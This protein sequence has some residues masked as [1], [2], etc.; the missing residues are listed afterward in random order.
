LKVE[1]TLSK[2]Q[3]D[4][5]LPAYGFIRR[6]DFSGEIPPTTQREINAAVRELNDRKEDW[7]KL[8]LPERIKILG[9]ILEN[10]WFVKERW[11][12]LS[13]EAKGTR[14]N[15]Y[16]EAE[17]WAIF[18]NVFRMVRL[19]RK[20]L[21]QIQENGRPV[22]PGPMSVRP[23]GQVVAKVFPQSFYDRLLLP[24]TTAEVWM[25]PDITLDDVVESQAR[26]YRQ[27]SREGKVTLV[28][29]AGNASMLVPADF[30]Y[31]LFVEGHVVILKLNPVNA[32]LGDTLKVAFQALIQPGFLRIVYGGAEEGGY[33]CHHPGVDQI[34]TTGS[35]KTYEDIVF[36]PGQEG[37]ARKAKRQPLLEK[38]F[39]AE[40]GNVTPVIVLPGP[41]SEKD[42][43]AQGERL[44]TWLVIN[45]GFNCLT[46]RVIVQWAGWEM[47]DALNQAIG[48]ALAAMPTRKAYYPQAH[49]RH[50]RYLTAHPEAR[51]FGQSD[52]PDR[53]PWT[54]I[55]ELNP[56]DTDDICFRNEPFCGL[57][58][59]TALQADGPEEFL[60]QAV[61]FANET[62]WGNL[63]A[64]ILAHPNS[65]EDK[66]ISAAVDRAV[67]GLRYGMV[68]IN[69]FA[70]LGFF[71]VTTTW[72]AFPGNDIYDI[73]SGI[74]VTSN[75]LM[76]DRPQK[77]V[78]RSPF[79]LSPDPF[80]P[81]SR[82]LIPF[83]KSLAS[84]QYRPNFWT[85][86]ALSWYAMRS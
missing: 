29:G 42:L 73:Q 56:E 69:Q 22:I 12:S 46:P 61:H 1:S 33:L 23:D 16:A 86:L 34:H 26:F 84:Y 14:G 35:D 11:V 85:M 6:A 36:G 64:T 25:Q 10:L 9:Q 31:K 43:R 78:V 21:R 52:N 50:A 44:A 58:S 71:A 54:F 20:S 67:A 27:N 47:R 13:V 30:L 70:G 62:L 40:L 77:S 51:L 41:W 5:S 15:T 28:L 53:L 2:N 80:S 49:Q 38:R 76:F 65:V 3:M 39:T 59:E 75:V 57:F 24:G 83:S 37:A 74:G 60:D 48:E 63:T 82:T 4:A 79:R 18:T 68:L 45:A 66:R 72:G 81:K 7:G 32:Y 17:E 8:E 55:S 19:L